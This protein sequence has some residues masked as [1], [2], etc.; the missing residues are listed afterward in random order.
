MCMSRRPQNS[1]SSQTSGGR[2]NLFALIGTLAIGLVLCALLVQKLINNDSDAKREP[3]LG[4]P[5][6]SGTT[7]AADANESRN[8]NAPQA[9]DGSLGSSRKAPASPSK[10]AAN[11]AKAPLTEVSLTEELT[12]RRTSEMLAA[13]ERMLDPAA[14]GWESESISEA[15]NACLKQLAKLLKLPM[16]PTAEQISQI[17]AADFQ[18]GPLYELDGVSVY[19]DGVLD[20]RRTAADAAQ[21]PQTIYRG[22]GGLLDAVGQLLSQLG[23]TEKRAVKFKQFRINLDEGKVRSTA[24]FHAFAVTP[25]GPVEINSTWELHWRTLDDNRVQMTHIQVSDFEQTSARIEQP[26]L[27]ADCTEAVLGDSPRYREQ[28][29]YNVSDWRERLPSNLNIQ[30]HGHIGLAVGDVNGDE[31]EDVYLSQPG[32]LPNALFIQQ[33]DG[34][35]KDVA[36]EA[37]VDFI[38]Y[39]YGALLVDLDNDGD[40]DLVLT[41]SDQLMILSNNGKGH[42]TV[43]SELP[44]IRAAYSIAAAD[45]DNDKDLDLYVCRH[46]EEGHEKGEF[47]VPYPFYD[48]N[49]GGENFFLR[50]DGTDSEGPWQFTDATAEVGFDADNHRFSFAA[51]WE[52]Y[53]N[54][55]DLDLYVANDFGRNSLYRNDG[56]TF[57]SVSNSAGLDDAAFG[58]SVSWG[59]YNRDGLMDMY[60]GNMFSAA[61]NRITFQDQFRDTSSSEA[62]EKYQRTARGN[63]LFENQGD[64]TF[65]DVSEQAGVTQG[66]WSWGSLFADI[67]NDGWE[68]LLVTNGFVTGDA[69][70]DL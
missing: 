8:A 15:T 66:R 26:T 5:A 27:F 25:S 7:L 70:D 12:T 19:T 43:R 61:G 3:H 30:Y 51:S 9:K 45:F 64:G 40:Q 1:P 37:G 35:V 55:G 41:V 62:R 63:S 60:V 65:R 56:G 6:S 68:D 57:T 10:V 44:T 39:T 29:A 46:R 36:A 14:D 18:S 58:M 48:A 33:P 17:A 32:G 59:D 13:D 67:N 31:R 47:P 34:T 38:N 53:D 24:Y 22:P 2:N 4:G 49:N 16:G 52:D 42:F 50:N 11:S 21:Q 20:V 54:D 28:L 23:E 69:V